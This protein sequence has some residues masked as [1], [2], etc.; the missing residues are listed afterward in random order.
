M[1]FFKLKHGIPVSDGQTPAQQET[2]APVELT[3]AHQLEA[4]P[5]LKAFYNAS[6]D[7]NSVQQ[8]FNDPN[9]TWNEESS[10]FRDERVVS[11]ENVAVDQSYWN[12]TA[13]GSFAN[14]LTAN[15]FTRDDI[16]KDE[17]LNQYEKMAKYKEAVDAF[18][19]RVSKYS[20][21]Q[22]IIAGLTGRFA[23]GE[24]GG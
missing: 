18:N 21:D 11:D 8:M 13:D 23:I 15:G 12:N 17:N 9:F 16:A 22:E 4:N 3:F 1:Y 5:N 6:A 24:I 2:E 19:K 14:V 20:G 10:S 7:K